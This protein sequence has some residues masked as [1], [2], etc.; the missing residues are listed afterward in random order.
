MDESTRRAQTQQQGIAPTLSKAGQNFAS[1]PTS[2]LGRQAILQHD[3][4]GTRSSW[5]GHSIVTGVPT[6]IEQPRR[7]MS[8]LRIVM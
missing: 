3:A 8:A 2:R 6:G 1:V 7:R 4:P 5:L